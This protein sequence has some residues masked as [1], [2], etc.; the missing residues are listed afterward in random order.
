MAAGAFAAYVQTLQYCEYAVD[1]SSGEKFFMSHKGDG[2]HDILNYGR[3]V[4]NHT[5]F[6]TDYTVIKDIALGGVDNIQKIATAAYATQQVFVNLLNEGP[7]ED[8]RGTW[9]Q[10]RYFFTGG[11][12]GGY[13]YGIDGNAVGF[14]PKIGMPPVLGIGKVTNLTKMSPGLQN[15]F[16]EG[17]KGNSI[18]NVRR[19]LLNNGFTQTITKN[20]SG[21][22]FTNKAGE[23]VRIMLR[24][25]GWDAR[26]M[27]Q[28]GN[29]LDDIGRV[30]SPASSHGITVFSW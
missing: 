29:Y 23:Q 30:A 9:G 28:Y 12:I 5:A 25:G 18:I 15:L 8:F 10:I 2:I 22:L 17:V 24:N 3:W 19:T 26:I 11:N 21:Y 7:K 27:N 16:K 13:H 14:S 6:I 20:K 4:D 1:L